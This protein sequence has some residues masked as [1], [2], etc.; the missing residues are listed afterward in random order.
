[1][2]GIRTFISDGILCGNEPGSDPEY[3]EFRR[4]SGGLGNLCGNVQL[5]TGAVSESAGSSAPEE[6]PDFVGTLYVGRYRDPLSWVEPRGSVGIF[7]N[8]GI[9][10]TAVTDR[11]Y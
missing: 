3:F 2:R 8:Y 11:I 1:M 9:K 6:Q 7:S 5:F 10:D 4:I